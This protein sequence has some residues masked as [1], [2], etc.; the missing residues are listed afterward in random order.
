MVFAVGWPQPFFGDVG[1]EKIPIQIVFAEKSLE[2]L[3]TGFEG[4]IFRVEE[5][6]DG[7]DF[8]QRND[9]RGLVAGVAPETA[10]AEIILQELKHASLL[11]WQQ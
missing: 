5:D 2:L 11:R 7:A 10:A 1:D 6:G 4:R 3:P 9:A 8:A